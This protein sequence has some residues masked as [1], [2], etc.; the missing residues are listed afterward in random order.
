[1]IL[2]AVPAWRFG[3]QVHWLESR[4]FTPIPFP[5]LNY[6]HD[7]KLLILALERLKEQCLCC[8]KRGW[9][10][11]GCLGCWVGRVSEA[12]SFKCW[13]FPLLSLLM[14]QLM[15]TLSQNDSDG[16]P[17]LVVTE[18]PVFDIEIVDVHLEFE[19]LFLFFSCEHGFI[20]LETCRFLWTIT[21]GIHVFS[22]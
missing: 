8:S 6:K 10:F 18:D 21:F 16:Q 7:T 4:K 15:A 14:T 20:M 3:P 5:P 19:M 17:V 22:P 13:M 9:I 2:Q 11:G 12:A 1:M